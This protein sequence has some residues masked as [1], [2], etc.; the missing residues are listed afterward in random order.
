MPMIIAPLHPDES[1]RQYTL[2]CLNILD[3][4]ADEYLETLVRVAQSA[5]GVETVLIS[6]IDR[7]RQWFKTRLGLAISETPR[8]YF[9]L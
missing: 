8:G 4:A 6:L 1:L 5:F 9:I 7:D 3:T 2:D